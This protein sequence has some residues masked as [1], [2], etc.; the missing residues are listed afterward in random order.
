M[1][2]NFLENG[3]NISGSFGTRNQGPNTGSYYKTAE[4]EKVNREERIFHSI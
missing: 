4:Q 2:H 1:E 3:N